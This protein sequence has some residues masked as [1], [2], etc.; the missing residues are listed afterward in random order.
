MNIFSE[1]ITAAERMIAKGVDR[2]N[3][4][5]ALAATREQAFYD[6]I[7]ASVRALRSDDQKLQKQA[8]VGAEWLEQNPP[9]PGGSG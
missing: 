9:M 7:A 1:D 5:L 2:F 8:M 3:L 4:A 6:G